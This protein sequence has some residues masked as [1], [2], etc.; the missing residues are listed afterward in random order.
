MR[1]NPKTLLVSV[2]VL[3]LAL[4]LFPFG[5]LGLEVPSF[6]AWLDGFFFNDWIHA[7]GHSTIF[8]LL[9]LALLMAF[10]KLRPRLLIFYA[11]IL[12]VA[13][14]Q[15]F[16]QL[17]YKQHLFVF[18]DSRDIVTDLIGA[19]LALLLVRYLLPRFSPA[20]HPS[21]VH[22]PSKSYD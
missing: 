22:K 13:V 12:V 3:A 10:P 17:L 1:P 9:G 11:L 21:P 16:F 6:G 5:W 7:L 20:P 4:A 14:G 8:F 18:D 2:L 15:E 19:T